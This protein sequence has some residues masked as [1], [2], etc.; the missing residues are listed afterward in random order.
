MIVSDHYRRE[1][2]NTAVMVGL[3]L[4]I[5]M[6]F[7]T[8]ILSQDMVQQLLN[9]QES[10]MERRLNGLDSKLDRV[11]EQLK[12]QLEHNRNLLDSKVDNG[13]DRLKQS[14]KQHDGI[15]YLYANLSIYTVIHP[16]Y[17][18]EAFMMLGGVIFTLF[19]GIR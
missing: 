5:V 6:I 14:M 2:E 7:A 13:F 8:A 3:F 15:L 18:L 17:S 9:I 11:F 12:H 4:Y 10:R 16:P 1:Q 19:L